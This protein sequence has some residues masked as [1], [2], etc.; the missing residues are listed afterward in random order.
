MRWFDG[1]SGES[2]HRHDDGHEQSGEPELEPAGDPDSEEVRDERQGQES[3]RDQRLRGIIDAHH[4]RDVPRTQHGH[5]GP[6]GGDA[7]EE[8]VSG[9]PG[10]DRSERASGVR[11]D[12]T[13]VGMPGRQRREC[14]GE[15]DR[16]QRDRENRH[17]AGRACGA[18]GESWQHE[19]AC[20]EHRGEIQRDP[21]Q[22]PESAGA[23]RIEMRGDQRGVPGAHPL[24]L[25][26]GCAPV[27]RH[28]GSPPRIGGNAPHF[29]RI[30][31]S[32]PAVPPL[33]AARL[34]TRCRDEGRAAL[35]KRPRPRRQ[36][37][38]RRRCALL[39]RAGSRA[40]PRRRAPTARRLRD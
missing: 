5:D 17:N 31:P 36:L 2:D 21:R 6:S 4:D 25:A 10:R 40:L 16:Q 24:T 32:A 13:G 29:A 28:S 11:G 38:H 1:G 39:R 9:G 15:R 3:E 34:S 8:P 7:E 22:Q 12:S 35:G 19:Q 27:R 14:S 30:P 37:R 18:S 23:R 33:P 20:T 26:L